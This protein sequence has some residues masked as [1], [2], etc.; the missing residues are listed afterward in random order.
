MAGREVAIFIVNYNMPERTDALAGHIERTDKWPYELIVI[1]NG[2]D[3]VSPAKSTNLWLPENQQTTG[4][5]LAGLRYADSFDKDWL[6]YWFLITSAEFPEGNDDPLFP[7]AIHLLS[8]P[9][10]VGVHPALTEDSTTAWTHLITRNGRYQPRR[11]W[12]IDNIASLWYAD[13]FDEIGRFDPELKYAWGIDLETCFKA[14]QQD[15]S[16]WIDER[17]RIKKVTNIGYDMKRMNMKADTRGQLAGQNMADVLS[18]RYG[19][20]WWDRMLNEG[21]RD[22][23]R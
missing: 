12:M 10:A 4:G 9:N 23:W 18:G 8:N 14:R 7:M 2:S 13:W 5:W 3:L 11:T 21:V 20:D 22:E 15:K 1:D 17:S 16:L 6:A 19:P